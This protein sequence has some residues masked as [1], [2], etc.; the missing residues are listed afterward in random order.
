MKLTEATYYSQ[1]ANQKWCTATFVKEC[2]G[3]C[4]ARAIAG[5]RGEYQRP[6]TEALTVGQYVD[7]ALTGD[8]MTWMTKHP[9]ILK[10][11]GTLKA[12]Y[13]KA[14]EMVERAQ[15]DPVFMSFLQG[16]HQ[17][18]L[19]AKLFGQYPFK[20][21]YDVLRKDAIIDLKTVK[22]MQPVYKPGQGRVDFATAWNWVL[23]LAIY[24]EIYR[25]RYKKKLPCYLAVI[26]KETPADIAVVQIEQERLDAELDWLEHAMPRID[27]LREGIIEPERCGCCDYCRET[28]VLT[29][30][31]SLSEYDDEGV[32]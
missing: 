10:R 27:A 7:E 24:Q 11:D 31:V 22:D 4:E 8:L 9:E 2:R 28:K 5:L 1:E 15:R 16:D 23:Q 12:E 29:G 18:I 25:T 17:R 14:Q 20:C 26:T 6:M 21:K 13:V 3:T 19:T 32:F 30:A